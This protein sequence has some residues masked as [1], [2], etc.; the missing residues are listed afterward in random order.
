MLFNSYE[1]LLIFLP[2]TFVIYCYLLKKKSLV[3]TNCFLVIVSLIFYAQWDI[4]YL[5]LLCGSI[6]FNY[7]VGMAIQK[8]K[9]KL[10]LYFGIAVNLLL[11]GYFKY[12]IFFSQ[13]LNQ[14][15]GTSFNLVHVILPLGIS[16]FTFTQTAFLIDAYRGEIVN[17]S[18]VRYALFVTIFPHLIAG[19]ILYHKDMLPQFS[20]EN[21][22]RIS[23]ENFAYGLSV[24]SIGLFKKVLIADSLAPIVRVV[25][26]NCD[27]VGFV[28]A[29][30]GAIAYTLQLYFD[31]SGYSEMALG[32][33]W[34]FNFK[35]PVNFN[36]PYQ[37]KSIID[38]WRRWHITLSNFLKMYV[39]IPLGGN[40]N[41]SVARMRN[42]LITMLVG[43]LWH[44][45]GW[46]FIIWGGL[47]GVFLVANHIWR[48]LEWRMPD[49][50]A[51]PLTFLAVVFAWVFFRADSIADAMIL[52]KTM[53]GMH[54]EW[55]TF[56][57]IMK[58]SVVDNLKMLQMESQYL[59]SSK[60]LCGILVLLGWVAKS[61]NTLNYLVAFKPGIRWA[62]IVCTLLILSIVNFNKSTEFLY[63]Q[64]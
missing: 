17:C 57:P 27:K 34:M 46:T 1:F 55:N 3:I 7:Y 11:L 15:A 14:L 53:L 26:S 43:G 22:Y 38:F 10:L 5:P 29:W 37:A 56:L 18:F 28:E 2:I 48:S 58:L 52:I 50:V 64:F 45:A 16:F 25:F 49:V 31:F 59:P 47:H 9:N 42:L 36:S 4:K 62:V 23:H 30:V 13:V 12:V 8:R 61:E 41:G 54:N 51:W 24:F 35:L 40:R 21:R 39:Y 19:P 44:G 60:M 33:G 63:F 20:E 32:I 6:L